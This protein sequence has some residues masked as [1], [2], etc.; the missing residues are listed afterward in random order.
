M[1]RGKWLLIFILAGVLLWKV[2]ERA[3]DRQ[4][5]LRVFQSATASSQTQTAQQE[6]LEFPLVVRDTGLIIQNLVNYEG[7]LIE[8]DSEEPAGEIM[9]LMVYNSSD[10]VIFSAQLQLQQQEREL[11]FSITWLPPHS[12]LLVLEQHGQAYQNAT[13]N[14]CD[15]LEL[16]TRE[17]G[18]INVEVLEQSAGLLVKNLGEMTARQVL[19]HYKQYIPQG[20]FYL[21]GITKT[22][23]LVDL[24]AGESR[25]LFPPGYAPGYSRVV[26]VET[27]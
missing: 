20:D 11:L 18:E 15:C 8:S 24:Q 2:A 7:V 23:E 5:V 22:A 1:G 6:S 14:R 16:E 9:A 27:K 17:Q 19:V 10:K 26:A 4:E 21:G 13:V 3:Q 12:R 25:D